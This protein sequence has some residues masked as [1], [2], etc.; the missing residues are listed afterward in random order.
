[1][2][3]LT[4]ACTL[5]LICLSLAICEH[6]A[7]RTWTS[8]QGRYK[9]EAE[10]V[11]HRADGKLI[12]RKTDGTLISVE[13]NKLSAA[14]RQYVEEL[15][16]K[17]SVASDSFDGLLLASRQL[18]RDGRIAE[19]NEKIEQAGA[20]ATSADD[21][22]QLSA[23][24]TLS[25]QL[26]QFWSAVAEAGGR[27]TGGAELEIGR[28]RVAVVE[29]SPDR[30]VLRALGKNC[31]FSLRQ[32]ET[33]PS[34]LALVL[35][36]RRLTGSEAAKIIAAYESLGPEANNRKL[37]ELAAGGRLTTRPLAGIAKAPLNDLLESAST[38]NEPAVPNPLSPDPTQPQPVD[39]VPGLEPKKRE[40]VPNASVVA[41]HRKE[42]RE[43]FADEFKA[44]LSKDKYALAK[45]LY[46]LAEETM[47]DD[48]AA[49]YVLYLESV[50]LAAEV[51][52]AQG[53]VQILGK[54]KASFEDEAITSHEAEALAVA[55]KVT[56]PPLSPKTVTFIGQRAS[57]L[58]D[59]AIAADDFA[60]AKIAVDTAIVVA[61]RMKNRQ[62]QALFQ[63]RQG[64]IEK[65]QRA[66]GK[67]LAAREAVAQNPD[68]AE[69][70]HTLSV[71]YCAQKNDWEK[72][73]K[74]LAKSDDQ[75]IAETAERDMKHPTDSGLCYELGETWWSLGAEGTSELG[76]A[77]K[78]RAAHW[79]GQALPGLSALRKVKAQKRI[80]EST[81][82]AE[83]STGTAPETKPV[84]LTSLPLAGSQGVD[85]DRRNAL[86]GEV[87][88]NKKSFTDGIWAQP[89]R[90]QIAR[91]G[92]K[93]DGQY[94]LLSGVAGMDDSMPLSNAYSSVVFSI[95][96]DDGKLLWKSAPLKR[97]GT[98]QAFKIKVQGV[99]TLYLATQLTGSSNSYCYAVWGGLTLLK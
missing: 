62:A 65:K 70:N 5:P 58:I 91:I 90:G 56:D 74:Y 25:S 28:A 47:A 19:A 22:D 88:V 60:A 30:L 21:K 63:K 46:Q 33:I 12:L 45:K 79:Y 83:N 98:G 93:L 31:R 97:R 41:K 24:R 77:F 6:L 37:W 3:K 32:P 64:E 14:D 59:E 8:A 26:A 96:N 50:E 86:H 94:S 61:R 67:I 84:A 85:L 66:F 2:T 9:I 76:P 27:L 42:I 1:M 18:L 95:Y 4:F 69:A 55:A 54:V 43:L 7:A 57:E 10:L 87:K 73:L 39:A 82:L 49:A 80:E 11:E 44:S 15:K 92:Y 71:Y 52:D 68:D 23:I 51:G 72:G 53:A 78:R 34:S 99:K 29:T 20:K 38:P 36:K 13:L 48:S 16:A 75:E 35:A 17:A 40:S 81:Q 89:Q